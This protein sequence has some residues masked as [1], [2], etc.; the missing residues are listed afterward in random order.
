M[1]DIQHHPSDSAH[2]VFEGQVAYLE[3]RPQLVYL[4][5]MGKVQV[6]DIKGGYVPKELANTFR[7]FVRQATKGSIL[8]PGASVKL[9]WDNSNA[10]P[11]QPHVPSTDFRDIWQGNI[12]SRMEA[13]CKVTGTD[14]CIMFS[15]PA[16]GRAPR[17]YPPDLPDAKLPDEKLHRAHL[18]VE[19]DQT[20]VQRE[21]NGMRNFVNMDF[22]PETLA[23]LRM[24]IMSDPSRM[25]HTI[26]D[27]TAR[28][29]KLWEDWET[30]LHHKYHDN[31][32]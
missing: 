3:L 30:Y 21:M 23:T 27:L 2:I 14:F 19:I 18:E 10:T 12:L 26:T 29:P 5:N 16:G 32:D 4:Q 31:K 22:E 24:A 6:K 17:S 15:K 9:Q 20:A 11:G 1:W 13:E 28:N 25:T 8:I 7:A